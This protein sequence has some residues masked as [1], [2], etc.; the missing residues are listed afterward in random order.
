MH[1]H[2]LSNKSS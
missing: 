2:F 1:M